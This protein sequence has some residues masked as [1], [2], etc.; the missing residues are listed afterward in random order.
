MTTP[1]HNRLTGRKI[2][3]TDGDQRAAL[4]I[5]RSLGAAGANPYVCSSAGD[6]LAG[7][8]RFTASEFR[9]SSPL[10]HPRAFAGDL[11]DIVDRNAI[12]CLLPV[13]EAALRS[14]LAAEGDFPRARLPFPPQDTFTAASDKRELMTTA[15]RLSIP[16]PSQI[17]LSSPRLRA[18]DSRSL[19]ALGF[20]LVLKPAV[21][22]TPAG[23]R[24]VQHSVRHVADR[25]ELERELRALPATA[26]PLLVQERI[27]GPGI[28]IFLL[29]W[30]GRIIARFAHRRLREKPP[31]GG[32]S[33]YRESIL[34]PADA[35]EHAE[36][37]LEEL[38]WRG[39][40]M[41]E[42][43][44]DKKSTRPYLM[45]ING[46]F[47]GSL[48]LAI[49]AGVDFPRLLVEAALGYVPDDPVE[50]RPGV[51]LRWL[52]GDLDHLLL[53]LFKSPGELALGRDAPGRLRMLA[54]FLV[55]W[56][57]GDRW[58]VLRLSDPRPFAWELRRWIADAL[59]GARS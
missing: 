29:R 58:E 54:S 35:L 56:R 34:P 36:A 1:S 11:R 27:V 17:V 40:A 7:A 23:E 31:S 39:V 44:R 45:E 55:P 25:T 6:S 14:V 15:A 52:L 21:S 51:R 57:R 12:D 59:P 47:W 53:R 26:F 43:K 33:V 37:L 16:V 3:V 10:I 4:A 24:L 49:D 2:L 18:P 22:V 28:G 32:V 48:Q 20:P 42:F 19:S 50:G 9:V 38:D 46:R 13:T 5:V 8:S 30:E 41:V